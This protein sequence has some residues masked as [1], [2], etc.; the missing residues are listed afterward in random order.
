MTRLTDIAVSLPLG[1]KLT[2]S[3]ARPEARHFIPEVPSWS[4]NAKEPAHPAAG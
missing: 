4:S 2:F 1:E 3:V